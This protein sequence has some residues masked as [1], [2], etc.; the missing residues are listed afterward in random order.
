VSCPSSDTGSTLSASRKRLSDAA[1]GEAAYGS[2]P[3]A[4][5]VDEV[6]DLGVAAV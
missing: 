5:S 6:E 4:V 3:A 2:G 1:V